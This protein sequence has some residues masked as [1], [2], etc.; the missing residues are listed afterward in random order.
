MKNGDI[1]RW[2]NGRAL[3]QR[4]RRCRTGNKIK[5]KDKSRNKANFARAHN[6]LNLLEEHDLP[7]RWEVK[8]ACNKM[9]SCLD[10]VMKILAKFSDFYVTNGDIH[11]GQ[12]ILSEME[13]IEERF[14]HGV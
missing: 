10:I 4:Y 6:S 1:G 13:K 12:R 5:K 11:K 3:W 14:L 9:D 7:S 8:T 2:D